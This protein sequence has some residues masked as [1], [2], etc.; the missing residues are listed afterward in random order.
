MTARGYLF[1]GRTGDFFKRLPNI[2]KRYKTRKYLKYIF[3]KFLILK[4]LRRPASNT[5][6]RVARLARSTM[7]GPCHAALTIVGGWTWDLPESSVPSDLGSL[8]VIASAPDRQAGG[9]LQGERTA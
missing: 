6:A 4:P 1:T 7:P 2:H 5:L 9:G 3:R 8:V